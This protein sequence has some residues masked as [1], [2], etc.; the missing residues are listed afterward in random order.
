VGLGERPEDIW[1]FVDHDRGRVRQLSQVVFDLLGKVHIIY[2]AA[3]RELPRQLGDVAEAFD[4]VVMLSCRSVGD[5]YMDVISSLS[6]GAAAL[7]CRLVV[8]PPLGNLLGLDDRLALLVGEG[9][10]GIF[11]LI[12]EC[13]VTAAR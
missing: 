4:Y 10:C 6:V 2:Q 8:L 9:R 1:A 13:L 7:A 3:D 11:Q 5:S 12:R